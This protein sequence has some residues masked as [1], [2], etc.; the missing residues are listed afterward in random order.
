MRLLAVFGLAVAGA[1]SLGAAELQPAGCAPLG[2]VQFLCGVVSPEDFAIVPRSDW[3]LASGN[4]A[5][6]G[7]IRAVN[8]RAHTVT[9][10]FPSPVVKARLDKRAYPSC[11][12][13]LDPADPDEKARFAAHGLYLRPGPRSTHTLYVVHHGARE[14]IEV[15]EVDASDKAPTLTWVGCVVGPE[16]AVFNAVVGLPDGGLAATN[17]PRNAPRA[18]GSAT[19]S[20]IGAIW[21]WHADTGWSPVT[22]SATAGINGLEISADGK[23]FY[24]AARGDWAFVRLQRGQSAPRRD[25]LPLPFQIDNLRFMPDGTLLAAGHSGTPLCSCPTENWH[26]SRIDPEAMTF[27]DLLRESYVEGFG[28][29]T[30]AVQV[31][32]DIWIG[33]NRGDRVGYFPAP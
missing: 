11:P 27:R 26:I 32:Q 25:M 33:T 21:E 1:L 28:A 30:V 9:N 10:L 14:S 5:G 2:K 29:S 3:M 19:G 31:G 16:N 4:R 17:T 20:R 23:W 6:Q 13:P 24:I 15:F 12:G 22:N 8:V 18:S 7:A